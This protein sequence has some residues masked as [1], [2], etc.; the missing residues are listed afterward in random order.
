VAESRPKSVIF[1]KSGQNLSLLLII[2]HISLDLQGF[3]FGMKWCGDFSVYFPWWC[4]CSQQDAQEFLISLLEG[5]QDDLNRV[6]DKN[7]K[8]HID[9]SSDVE[10]IR[11][12]IVLYFQL[13]KSAATFLHFVLFGTFAFDRSSFTSVN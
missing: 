6:R 8:R 13:L 3:G 7:K 10:T 9:S 1:F 12:D 4:L 2:F 11:H 5:L